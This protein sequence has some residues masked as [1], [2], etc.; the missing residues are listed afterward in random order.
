MPSQTEQDIDK[1]YEKLLAGNEKSARRF[2]RGHV[3]QMG[4]I[5]FHYGLYS[6]EEAIHFSDDLLNAKKWRYGVSVVKILGGEFEKA[7][8]TNAAE[9]YKLLEWSKSYEKTTHAKMKNSDSGMDMARKLISSGIAKN[10]EFVYKQALDAYKDKFEAE[11]TIIVLANVVN[12]QNGLS[13]SDKPF[14]THWLRVNGLP[15]HNGRDMKKGLAIEWLFQNSKGKYQSLI[16]DC[17]DV[18]ARNLSG[19]HGYTV[20]ARYRRYEFGTETM[21]FKHVLSKLQKI[22][23]LQLALYFRTSLALFEY[24]PDT[25]FDMADFG[26][27]DWWF[28]EEKKILFIWQYFGNFNPSKPRKSIGFY[29]PP[30]Q[31]KEKMVSIHFDDQRVFPYDSR[32]KAG[33][34]TRAAVTNIAKYEKVEAVLISVMPNI[35]PF[36]KESWIPKTYVMGKE[37]LVV[38]DK[39]LELQVDRAA[40]EKIANHLAQYKL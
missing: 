8:K 26:I 20:N 21:S 29:S 28:D 18:K 9:L 11:T 15:I 34:G 6:L 24:D 27:M 30:A 3:P 12:I 17:Y 2:L 19:H 36:N 40:A 22:S 25:S 4:Y 31:G 39:R 32:V 1:G 7:H 35:E 23:R 33:T 38:G 16:R 13:F 5:D 14:K 10:N 37:M